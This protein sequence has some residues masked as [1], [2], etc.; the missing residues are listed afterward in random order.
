MLSIAT[1]TSRIS[2]RVPGATMGPWGLHYERTQTWWEMSGAWHEYLARCQYLLRQGLF[3]ADLLYLRPESPNQTYLTPN[4]LPPAGYRYDEISA[5][6][7]IQ[8]VSVRDGK[9]V[10]PDGMSYRVLVLPERTVMTPA[11]AEKIKSLV[12][13]GATVF[14]PKPQASPSLQDFPQCDRVVAK[15]G[16]EVW[17]DCDGEKITEHRFGRGKVVRGQPLA[18]VLSALQTP[19]DF[20]SD[21]NLNWIHRTVGDAEIYFVANPSDQRVTANCQFRVKDRTPEIWNPQTGERVDLALFEP[22]ATGVRD[23]AVAGS[24]RLGV[25]G[26]PQARWQF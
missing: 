9:L 22:S 19:P 25:C 23:S 24:E 8:R 16:D 14:G 4:P 5:E 11:L 21:A 26:F 7:L 18:A 10:L 3:V 20:Q 1:R 6:A 13:A 17:G 2:N 12:A 15:I